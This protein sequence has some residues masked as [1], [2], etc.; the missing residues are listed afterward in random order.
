MDLETLRKKLKMLCES[1]LENQWRYFNKRTIENYINF[2]D[3][4][5]SNEDKENFKVIFSNYL[6]DVEINFEPNA[7]YSVGLYYKYL[8]RVKEYYRKLGFALVPGIRI[9][10]VMV[11]VVLIIG[12]YIK[13][14]IYL[15]GIFLAIVTITFLRMFFK[16]RQNKT[17]GPGY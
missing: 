8:L 4:I 17:Y 2:L 7:T 5:K 1:I 13:N 3:F 10:R 6:D 12:Y 14:Y 11:V 15:E 9:F 16:L